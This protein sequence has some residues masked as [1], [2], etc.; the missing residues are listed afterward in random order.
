MERSMK[1]FACG[2][3]IPGC[4]ATFTGTSEDDVLRQAID[5]ARRDHGLQE[6]APETIALARTLIH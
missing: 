4:G 6:I 2:D 3:V 1:H 5:H